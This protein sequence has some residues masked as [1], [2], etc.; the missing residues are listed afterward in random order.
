MEAT[1]IHEEVSP[2]IKQHALAILLGA[3]K[4]ALDS[5][6][7]DEDETKLLELAMKTFTKRKDETGA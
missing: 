3:A 7:F 1:T 6:T 4:K 5:G 2:T